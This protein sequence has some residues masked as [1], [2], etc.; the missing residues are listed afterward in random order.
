MKTKSSVTAAIAA[1]VMVVAIAASVFAGPK[2]TVPAKP[3]PPPRV[4]PPPVKPPTVSC[5]NIPH[6]SVST[7]SATG[8]GYTVTREGVGLYTITYTKP[9]ATVPKL[10][11]KPA[12]AGFDLAGV[13]DPTVITNYTGQVTAGYA[14]ISESSTGATIFYTGGPD[15]TSLNCVQFVDEFGN[16]T[17]VCWYTRLLYGEV[18]FTFAAF[19]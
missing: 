5:P 9:F 2:P 12:L 1:S 15:L 13:T 6:G 3:C 18:P 14:V 10:L 8:S 11:L 7:N 17:T 19:E 16:V 4:C